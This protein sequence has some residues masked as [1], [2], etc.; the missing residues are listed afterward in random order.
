MKIYI[1]DIPLEGLYVELEEQTEVNNCAAPVSAKL[2][3][4]KVGTEVM[5]KGTLTSDVTFQCSRC[6]KDFIMKISIPVDVMYHPVEELK[7]EETH[8]IKTD[9]LDMDFYSGEDLDIL[10]LMNEQIVLNI[11]MKPLC[12]ETCKGIC[13]KCGTDLNTGSC[14]CEARSLDPRFKSLKTLLENK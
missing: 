7:G 2:K 10:N 13:L 9:E 3:I 4:E 11:P 14:S 8:E 6:L 5:V 1:P 12:S